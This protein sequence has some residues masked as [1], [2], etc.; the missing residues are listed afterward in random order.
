MGVFIKRNAVLTKMVDII[1]YTIV[2]KLQE[3][4]MIV[5][6]PKAISPNDGPIG[7]FEGLSIVV[8]AELKKLKMPRAKL[9]TREVLD[10]AMDR[11]G[12][13]GD[14]SRG[15]AFVTPEIELALELTLS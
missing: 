7:A 11:L 12:Y 9:V 14:Y 10:K 5:G 1:P 2:P 4:L 6:F 13:I 15:Y 8:N 3:Y